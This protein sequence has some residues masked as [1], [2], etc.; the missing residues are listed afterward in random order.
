[1]SVALATGIVGIAVGAAIV[2][3]GPEA[4]PSPPA[5]AAPTAVENARGAGAG[6]AAGPSAAGAGSA[7]VAAGGLPAGAAELPLDPGILA[8]AAA[9]TA[10]P[11]AA[12]P[13]R[14]EA[15]M[16]PAGSEAVDDA[17]YTERL[18]DLPP[19]I[20]ELYEQQRALRERLARQ[21]GL[22]NMAR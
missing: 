7:R 11:P 17:L 8:G 19:D 20:R 22:L 21:Q 12:A 2:A 16:R 1:V 14:L 4:D 5:G 15:L 10:M 9:G 13:A 18:E 6:E 3:V